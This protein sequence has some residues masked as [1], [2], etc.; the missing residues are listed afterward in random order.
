MRAPIF[1]PVKSQ[2]SSGKP[3]NSQR[4]EAAHDHDEDQQELAAG[5][6]VRRKLE[7]NKRRKCCLGEKPCAQGCVLLLYDALLFMMMLETTT[8]EKATMDSHTRISTAK[9]FISHPDSIFPIVIISIEGFSCYKPVDA[10]LRTF[11]RPLI[12]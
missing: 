12:D 7:K 3:G 5:Y 1:W 8:S 4:D 10:A 6:R 2:S 9:L 11:R